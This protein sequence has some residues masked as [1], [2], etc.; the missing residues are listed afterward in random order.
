[1][2][3]PSAEDLRQQAQWDGAQGQSRTH[4]LSE[5]SSK[6]DYQL[7]LKT[8]LHMI[9]SISPSVMIPEHRLSV[10]L[11]EVK[12]VWISNC[13][14]HNTAESP[15]LYL[16]HNCERDDFPTRS[17]LDLRHH[18]DEVWFLQYSHDGT[19]LASTS[20]DTTIIIYET[21][22]YKV[23]HQLDE[24]EGSGVTHLAWSPD[25][26]KIITC[27]SQPENSAR[28][29][30]VKVSY[31]SI[32][33]RA[34]ANGGRLAHV[35]NISATSLTHAQQRLGHPLGSKWLWALKTTGWVAAS[36]TSMDLSSTTSATTG[37]NFVQMI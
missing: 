18:K 11:D 21:S 2:M 36:G 3:S 1:M 17:V 26:T 23:L 13:L 16:D 34:P 30:D 37:R 8:H 14:Y 15:S 32:S 24:H 28:I 19:K 35:Y 22:T 9:E 25:D 27:C 6:Q 31:T 5:L 7:R 12:D 29:W 20:K 4:L 33:Y 10:L